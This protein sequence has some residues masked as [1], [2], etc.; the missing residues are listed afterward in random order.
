MVDFAE[1]DCRRAR[2]NLST[3]NRTTTSFENHVRRNCGPTAYGI[4]F[5][6]SVPLSFVNSFIHLSIYEWSP[7]TRCCDD[8]FFFKFILT[9]SF[10]RRWMQSANSIWNEKTARLC[11]VS[12]NFTNSHIFQLNADFVKWTFIRVENWRSQN[13]KFKSRIQIKFG[14]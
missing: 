10:H 7:S 5:F 12:H 9:R 13:I 3:H 8:I 2:A 4:L 6:S 1:F 11:N 14:R